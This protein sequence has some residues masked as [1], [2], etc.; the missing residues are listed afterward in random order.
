MTDPI[1]MTHEP[2]D[3]L[4]RMANKALRYVEED[5]AFDFDE[6]RAI[7]F[8]IDDESTGVGASGFDNTAHILDEVPDS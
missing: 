3:H 1:E 6:M 2:T 4:T 8:V 7:V 5:E